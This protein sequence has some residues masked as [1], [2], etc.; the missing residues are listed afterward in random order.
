M[1]LQNLV[2]PKI[3]ICTEEKLYFNEAKGDGFYNYEYNKLQLKAGEKIR[4]G[5]YFNSFLADRWKRY[6]NIT[7]VALNLKG[8]GQGILKIYRYS[9]FNGLEL[10]K[11][12]NLLLDNNGTDIQI[13]NQAADIYGIIYFEFEAQ[14]DS[15]LFGGDFHTSSDAF[16]QISLGI[17]ITTFKRELYVRRNMESLENLLFDKI[18][19]ENLHIFIIDN[20]QT[21]SPSQNSRISVVPN[22][23]YGGAGGFGRGMLELYKSQKYN[24]VV[25]C[26]DDAVYEPEAF[27]R[28][29][30]FLSL[31]KNP[32]L[33]VGGSMLK[34]DNPCYIHE[35]GAIFCGLELWP[36]KNMLDMTNFS[37][38][39]N[40]NIEEY[41]TYHAW[42]FFACPVSCV[43]KIGLPIPVF[44]Q[45]DDIEYSVRLREHDYETAELNGICV[46][47]E[48]FQRKSSTATN[49]YWIR[50]D[51][52]VSFLHSKGLSKLNYI[53]WYTKYFL[54]SLLVYRYDRA[55]MML[56]G[57]EDALKGPG[58]L[59]NLNPSS[60]HQWLLKQQIEKPHPIDRKSFTLAKYN[61]PVRH[62]KLKKIV[63]LVTLNGMLL[64]S[65]LTHHG[66]KV[67]D[68]GYVLEPLQSF[69][70]SAVFRKETVLYIDDERM[71]GF[72]VYRSSKKFWTLLFKL[73]KMDMALFTH[74][75]SCRKAYR[76]SFSTMTSLEFWNKY[77]G[78]NTVE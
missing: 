46:W 31:A 56:R 62:D 16:Q 77:V 13:F 26:D 41:A 30:Y 9:S 3:G 60:Y 1:I 42:W 75:D 52:I 57:A 15:R 11:S 74:L 65:F 72:E 43:E 35:S 50:N 28:L 70:M 2:F 40:F 47:H 5:T 34:L 58:F 18:P 59:M 49:Y 33:C 38:L 68:K 53:R 4:F 25:F 36:N 6:T 23:N 24:Y 10:I 54:Q 20:G 55:Q 78:N 48:S 66:K 73:I 12:Q 32:E 61:R 29:F 19:D 14:T 44:F 22:K 21:L 67:T 71:T 7:D 51:M 17:V 8:E 64:P 27:L 45:M 63:M 39:I 37:S 76:K 69:R